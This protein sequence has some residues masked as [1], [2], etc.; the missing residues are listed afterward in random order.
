MV[1]C[2]TFLRHRTSIRLLTWKRDDFLEGGQR[3]CVVQSV[4]W[5]IAPVPIALRGLG[6]I[7]NTVSLTACSDQKWALE[8][9]LTPM[10][11]CS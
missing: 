11:P 9:S 6:K 2:L 4:Y 5:K 1:F 10:Y 8:K 7:A 3:Q